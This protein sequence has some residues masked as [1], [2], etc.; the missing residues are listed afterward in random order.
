MGQSVGLLAPTKVV[1]RRR[2]LRAGA[3][4]VCA[5]MEDSGAGRSVCWSVAKVGNASREL[6][7]EVSASAS[8]LP[9]IL[10][11]IVSRL[12]LVARQGPF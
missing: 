12:N 2:P 8:L 7:L 11:L 9:D 4:G 5:I 10:I 3:A 6:S 1:V